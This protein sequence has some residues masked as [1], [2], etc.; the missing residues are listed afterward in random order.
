[1][2]ILSGSNTASKVIEGGVTGDAVARLV[3]TAGG[4]IELGSGS[5]ARDTNLYRSAADVLK[6]D[7]SLT[8]VG[9]LLVASGGTS[10]NAVD[11]AATTNYAAY[12]LRTDGSDQWAVQL[13]NDET[14]NL[15]ITDSVNGKTALVA[16][17]AAAAASLQ[18]VGATAALGGGVGVIGITNATTVPGT[19]PT[20]GGVLYAEGGALKWRGSS[21]TVTPIAAA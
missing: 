16:I 17:P 10:I 18:L 21:G 6:T 9:V 20:G 19:N 4:T 3:V 1:M 5:A 14:N 12:V 15:N 13:V 7:D 8:V 11:R 2:T